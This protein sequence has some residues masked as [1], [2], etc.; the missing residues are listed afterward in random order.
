MSLATLVWEV[1]E[2]YANDMEH[3]E[4]ASFDAGEWSHASVIHYYKCSWATQRAKS[5]SPVPIVAEIISVESQRLMF[6]S[7][8]CGAPHKPHPKDSSARHTSTNRNQGHQGQPS[9][10]NTWASLWV[11]V[12]ASGVL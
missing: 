11:L 4:L 9:S 7:Q 2:F 5:A 1:R 10:P 3:C 12:G 8:S 6:S